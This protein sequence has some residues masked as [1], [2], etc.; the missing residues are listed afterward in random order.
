ML[1]VSVAMKSSAAK[2]RSS[3]ADGLWTYD[4]CRDLTS[5]IYQRRVR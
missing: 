3:V 4:V 5:M 2:G 1:E